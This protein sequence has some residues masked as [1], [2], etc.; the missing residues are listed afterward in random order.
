MRSCGCAWGTVQINHPDLFD[1][2][3]AGIIML[4]MACPT[5]RSSGAIQQMRQ[6]LK[7]AKYDLKRWRRDT[8]LRP[9]LELLD[10]EGGLGW[11]LVCRLVC[12][13]GP[14]GLKRLSADAAL[15]HPYFL[16]GVDQAASLLGRLSPNREPQ[17]AR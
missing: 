6:E 3:S 14:L 1:T 17:S 15:R 5:L 9:D 2:Y 8:R 11:D 10:L 16:L 13:R 4:Q 12:E 7:A